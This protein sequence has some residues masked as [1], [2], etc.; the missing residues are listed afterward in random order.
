[1]DTIAIKNML[2]EIGESICREIHA[3]FSTTTIDHRSL[4]HQE[5]VE[6]TIYQID[7]DVEDLL[8]PLL[9]RR[10]A[11]LGGIVLVAEGIGDDSQGLA[12]PDTMSS[13][14]AAV[15]ILVDPI[16]GTRGIMYD[17]RSAFFLAGA[18]SNRGSANTLRDIETAVMVE[19]PT[20]RSY[21]SDTFWAIKNRGAFR[22]TTN[23]NTGERVE[24]PIRPSSSKSIAGGFAQI[25]RFFPPGR[26]RL[27]EIEEALIHRLFPH[28]PAGK[29]LLFEDQYI[30]TGGQLH[31][32]LVGHDRFIAD[33]R[34]C[35]FRSMAEK[36]CIPG[37]TCHPYDLAGLL[38][39]EEAGLIITDATGGLLDAPMDTTSAIDWIGYANRDI[40]R[41]VE[42]V[43]LALLKKY[44]MIGEGESR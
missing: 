4:V 18:A 26:H 30:S 11:G 17:K 9:E 38:I 20:S 36:E 23:L 2:C 1:M 8:L 3:S 29:A 39:A 5:T 12:I 25:S 32:L 40:Q 22:Y 13:E 16:D 15:R 28:P 21:L 7:R 34:A 24:Q 14:E 44:R 37:L 6:D 35:L 43:L 27:A 41:E 33:L 19:L 42:P 10:A 31:E